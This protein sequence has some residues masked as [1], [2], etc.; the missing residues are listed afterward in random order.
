MALVVIA[1]FWIDNKGSLYIVQAHIQIIYSRTAHNSLFIMLLH[2]S[3]PG[4]KLKGCAAGLWLWN[5]P[6]ARLWLSDIPDIPGV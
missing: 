6:C 5:Y 3:F 1:D 2:L 4:E